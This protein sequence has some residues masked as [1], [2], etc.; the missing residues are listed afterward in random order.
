M[1]NDR[2]SKLSIASKLKVLLMLGG[3]FFIFLFGAIYIYYGAHV[4]RN[5]LMN[6]SVRLANLLGSR[7][8]ASIR[9]QNPVFAKTT[10]A[11]AITN[12][13]YRRICL[14][15]ANGNV[16][17]AAGTEPC[18]TLARERNGLFQEKAAIEGDSILVARNMVADNEIVGAITIK[19]SQEAILAYIMIQL[20][21]MAIIALASCVG[22]YFMANYLQRF[23]SRPILEMASQVQMFSVGTESNLRFMQHRNDELGKVTDAFNRILTN[24]ENKLSEYK[25]DNANLKKSSQL[26][27]QQLERLMEH[28]SESLESF[29]TYTEML[30]QHCMGDMV[31]DYASYQNDVATSLAI[32]ATNFE[33]FIRVSQVYA[34][35]IAGPRHYINLSDQLKIF[36]KTLK[37]NAPFMAIELLDRQKDILPLAF[38]VHQLAWDEIFK[39]LFNLYNILSSLVEFSPALKITVDPLSMCISMTLFDK[40]QP[41]TPRLSEASFSYLQ[42]NHDE[43]L[44]SSTE[45]LEF[46]QDFI[47]DELFTCEDMQ[48]FLDTIAYIAHANSVHI[49]HVFKKGM[50]MIAM[51]ISQL[52][53][54]ESLLPSSR[55]VLQ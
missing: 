51:D 32:H 21:T 29:N 33:S 44:Q 34:A 50:F 8:I 10:I 37:L 26:F 43:M 39:L 36:I 46:M 52:V 1:I 19:R 13:N 45:E 17:A 24:M 4:L 6:D 38:K 25:E 11:D 18:P 22:G 3:L 54:E 27:L 49:N 20:R 47:N 40:A 9:F 14:Y 12:S 41:N 7:N 5:T 35:A 2:Y 31:D 23:I 30:T 28:Y 16:F 55:R 48:F 42:Q 15:D 53:S